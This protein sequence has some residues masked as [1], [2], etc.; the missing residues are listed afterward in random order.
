MGFWCHNVI[1]QVN[2]W[3]LGAKASLERLIDGVWVPEIQ[4]REVNIWAFGAKT[5]LDTG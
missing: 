4:Y 1:R 5:S 3:A 2:R